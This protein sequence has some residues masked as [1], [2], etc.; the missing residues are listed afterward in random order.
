[1]AQSTNQIEWEGAIKVVEKMPVDPIG[2]SKKKTLSQKSKVYTHI[3]PNLHPVLL[4][5]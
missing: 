4:A 2:T 1:M 5:D 3:S